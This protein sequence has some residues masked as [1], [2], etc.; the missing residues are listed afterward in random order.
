[1]YMCPI[2]TCVAHICKFRCCNF[3]NADQLMKISMQYA[4]IQKTFFKLLQ[5]SGSES[6][7]IPCLKF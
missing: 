6:H 2:L 4:R 3:M 5:V 7:A 1:M